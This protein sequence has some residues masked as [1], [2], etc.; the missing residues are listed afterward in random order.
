MLEAIE[1]RI[2]QGLLVEQR[3]PVRQIEVCGNYCRDAAVALILAANMDLSR[4][5]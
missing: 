4:S 3:V 1:Q 2:D 5:L